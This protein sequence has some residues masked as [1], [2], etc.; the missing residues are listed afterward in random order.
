MVSAPCHLVVLGLFFGLN[1]LGFLC[2]IAR[3]G[4]PLND[5]VFRPPPNL[6]R[7]TLGETRVVVKLAQQAE[8]EKWK[9]QKD[10]NLYVRSKNCWVSRSLYTNRPNSRLFSRDEPP[11]SE[12]RKKKTKKAKGK[13]AREAAAF[14]HEV[15]S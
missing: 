11:K 4:T 7:G 15:R 10:R 8:E 3:G 13:H 12:F 5:E 2:F 14:S 9:R 6:T 1:A